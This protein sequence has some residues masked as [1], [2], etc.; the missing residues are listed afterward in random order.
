MRGQGHIKR[1]N[2]K[3]IKKCFKTLTH[4]KIRKCHRHISPNM[5][6]DEQY[7]ILESRPC[8]CRTPVLIIW[9][10]DSEGAGNSLVFRVFVAFIIVV[11]FRCPYSSLSLAFLTAFFFG[12]MTR[13]WEENCKKK[14]NKKGGK[15]AKSKCLECLIWP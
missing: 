5:N 14:Q 6:K 13:K 11:I 2:N 9:V 15:N 4:Q 12:E 1:W 3:R 7:M 10:V 8:A